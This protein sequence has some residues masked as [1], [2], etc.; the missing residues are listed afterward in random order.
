MALARGP[1]M[2][3][4]ENALGTS[5]RV[6]HSAGVR[7]PLTRGVQR[8]ELADEL[9]R[10]MVGAATRAI[11]DQNQV[12]LFVTGSRVEFEVVYVSRDGRDRPQ[13][14]NVRL[15][16][17]AANTATSTSPLSERRG[18]VKFC[19]PIGYGFIVDEKGDREYYV[20]SASVPGGYLREGGF[21]SFDIQ[22]ADDGKTQAVNVNVLHWDPIGNS[23]S[24]LIDM[25]HPKWA[26]L[27][28]SIHLRRRI[29][30]RW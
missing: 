21:L 16:V 13:A 24:D 1:A 7:T 10:S 29:L 30:L 8:V 12:S 6:S 22:T 4:H 9:H 5:N 11:E 27:R 25:G 18:S 14:R 2:G 17:E 15:V 20:K 26:F 28:V 19:D 3:R 23:Y